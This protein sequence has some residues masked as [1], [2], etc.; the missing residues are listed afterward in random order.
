MW[1]SDLYEYAFIV[2]G[3][4]TICPDFNWNYSVDV[5]PGAFSYTWTLPSGW[6]GTSTTNMIT[7]DPSST[8]GT[9]QCVV[10]LPSG[11]RTYTLSVSVNPGCN[12]ALD[13]D[14]T[15]DFLELPSG[16]INLNNT[17]FTVEFW[18][19][20]ATNNTSD[21]VINQGPNMTNSITYWIQKQ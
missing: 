12:N 1:K 9:V 14:G 13:F 3:N 6:S 15:N 2:N 11:N 19:K 16:A 18:A 5:V 21:M 7:V 4:K 17:S 10:S 8:S 20:R